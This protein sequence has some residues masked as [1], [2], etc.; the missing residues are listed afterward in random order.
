MVPCLIVCQVP[1]QASGLDGGWDRRCW[2]QSQSQGW[3]CSQSQRCQ[4][5]GSPD[6]HGRSRDG[7]SMRERGV[8]AWLEPICSLE[9]SVE[10]C[11]K[12]LGTTWL[13]LG[14]YPWAFMMIIH[15]ES[16]WNFANKKWAKY[17]GITIMKHTLKFTMCIIT[18]H[19]EMWISRLFSWNSWQILRTVN[20]MHFSTMN[21]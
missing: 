7:G 8:G 19:W 9:W 1:A 15:N 16:P 6:K 5:R 12:S 3:A 2:S 4:S 11:Y 18:K 13:K 20:S 14:N 10:Q 21:V 17:W